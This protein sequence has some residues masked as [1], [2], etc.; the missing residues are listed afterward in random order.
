MSVYLAP[1]A[2][3]L[4]TDAAPDESIYSLPE[5]LR[6]ALANRKKGDAVASPFYPGRYAPGSDLLAASGL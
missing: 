6:R 5:Y 2:L 1:S 3:D 4:S